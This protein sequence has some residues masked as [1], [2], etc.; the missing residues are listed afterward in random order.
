M[1][2]HLW[3]NLVFT[4]GLSALAPVMA[5]AVPAGIQ[6]RTHIHVDD[7][8]HRPASADGTVQQ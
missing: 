4:L 5:Q 7:E 2:K 8:I 6:L 1:H 3:R